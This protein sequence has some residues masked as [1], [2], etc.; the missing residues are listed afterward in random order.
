MADL[1]YYE[2]PNRISRSV[3]FRIGL[4]N[5]ASTSILCRTAGLAMTKSNQNFKSWLLAQSMP[6][7]AQLRNL[8]K[9]AISASVYWLLA[10]LHNS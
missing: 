6:S 4:R 9:N 10:G 1:W 5:S 2:L 7:Y 3:P 8:E